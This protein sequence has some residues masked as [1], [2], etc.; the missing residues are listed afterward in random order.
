M[1]HLLLLV[2]SMMLCQ[3]SAWYNTSQLQDCGQ[4]PMW[5]NQTQTEQLQLIKLDPTIPSPPY[6]EGEYYTTLE[7][8]ISL[9]CKLPT[10]SSKSF[11][12]ITFNS[13][14]MADMKTANIKRK[15]FCNITNGVEETCDGPV[16]S[17]KFT[18]CT[19]AIFDSET[20]VGFQD[21]PDNFPPKCP[22]ERMKDLEVSSEDILDKK[23][24]KLFFK[25]VEN[26]EEGTYQCSILRTCNPGYDKTAESD[27]QAIISVSKQLYLKVYPWPD[28]RMD[29][30][31]ISSFL[32]GASLLMI[33]SA[34]ITS[35]KEDKIDHL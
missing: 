35:Q 3:V 22:E 28:Y 19:I 30:L 14:Y 15:R 8:N 24:I 34:V 16:P 7:R 12:S 32:G 2:T 6:S 25:K 11:I 29:L 13:S 10:I 33:I 5:D 27:K 20:M 31:V 9:E 21:I 18:T 1:F 26:H 17:A 23:I 4:D